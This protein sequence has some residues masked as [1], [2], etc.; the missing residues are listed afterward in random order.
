M[1]ACIFKHSSP[2]PHTPSPPVNVPRQARHL[3]FLFIVHSCELACIT[4]VFFSLKSAK[5]K[6]SGSFSASSSK[7][8]VSDASTAASEV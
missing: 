6:R 4:A 2:P 1:I 8:M 7:S 3:V 5:K